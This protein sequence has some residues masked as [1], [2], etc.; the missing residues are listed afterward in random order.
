[1]C[2]I[3][4][5]AGFKLG[6]SWSEGKSANHSTMKTYYG[7]SLEAPCWGAS[8]EY[9]QH[10]FSWRNQKILLYEDTPSYMEIC[11][12]YVL[13]QTCVLCITILI[14]VTNNKYFCYKHSCLEIQI[15]TW[16]LEKFRCPK[17][18]MYFQSLTFTT[19]WANSADNKLVISFLIFPR[20]QDLTFHAK[21]LLWR[22]FA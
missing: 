8:N 1:M 14:L 18:Y 17:E 12:W 20:K 9:P 4:P 2:W 10:T 21:C 22:Q 6:T 15:R 13:V 7:Y 3:L 16:T 11:T 5:P 19:L